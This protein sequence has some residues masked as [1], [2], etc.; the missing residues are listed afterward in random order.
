LKY[1][2]NNLTNKDYWEDFWYDSEEILLIPE[3]SHIRKWI[4]EHIP[5]CEEKTAIELGCY[6]GRFLTIFGDLG[7]TLYGIDQVEKTDRLVPYNLRKMGYMCGEFYK[8]DIFNFYSQ[9]LKFDL[10][11]SF[12]L[13]EHFK[14]YDELIKIHCNLVA[15]EGYLI[16]EVPNFAG[17][18]HYI[19]RRLFDRKV[20]STHYIPAMNTT[21]WAKVLKNEGFEILYIGGIG[22]Y[23]YHINIE[24]LSKFKLL[25]Y[26]IIK[27]FEFRVKKYFPSDSNVYS[28]YRG[29]IAK[30]INFD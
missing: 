8:D 9:K 15:P 29:V 27:V 19:L 22:E 16:I 1:P 2:K 12:G 21:K 24:G 4:F 7:Y 3:K 28:P 14:N 30:K 20:F 10:V 23:S 13:I 17:L 26:R 18:P 6:P 25:L 5:P 11:A